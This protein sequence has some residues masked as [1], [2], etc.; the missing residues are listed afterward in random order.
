MIKV[1]HDGSS[2]NFKNSLLM[3]II[4]MICTSGYFAFLI[5][6]KLF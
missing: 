5:A 4:S 6:T 3:N 2:A 1:W